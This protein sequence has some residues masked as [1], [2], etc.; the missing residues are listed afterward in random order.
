LTLEVVPGA[1][2]MQDMQD[3]QCALGSVRPEITRRVPAPRNS[4]I[5]GKT[6]PSALSRKNE[7]W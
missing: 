7:G 4:A 5:R 1:Y 3:F 2:G 6:S